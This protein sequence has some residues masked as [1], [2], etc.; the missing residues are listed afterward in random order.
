MMQLQR[1]ASTT[2]VMMAMTT[3]STPGDTESDNGLLGSST[4]YTSDVRRFSVPTQDINQMRNEHQ[5]QLNNFG[6]S[7]ENSL[8]HP[9]TSLSIV[10]QQ[11]QD[12]YHSELT[13]GKTMNSIMGHP[14]GIGQPGCI[15]G[16]DSKESVIFVSFRN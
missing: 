1:V 6:G 10:R 14:A 12:S 15:P 3:A 8:Q 9:S 4:T 13:Q 7:T 11:Q 16:T 2:T 5:Q